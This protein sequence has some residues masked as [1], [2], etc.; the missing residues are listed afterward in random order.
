MKK[1]IVV[2]TVFVFICSSMVIFFN[3]KNVDKSILIIDSDMPCK[4]LGLQ[5]HGDDEFLCEVYKR[6]AHSSQLKSLELHEG[7]VPYSIGRNEFR[8]QKRVNGWPVNVSCQVCGM[9]C[10]YSDTSRLSCKRCSRR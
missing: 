1:I 4:Y 6:P 5:A 8:C 3:A 7:F 2:T 9:S 10:S